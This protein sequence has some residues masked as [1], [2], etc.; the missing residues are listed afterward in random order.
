MILQRP[1]FRLYF[2]KIQHYNNFTTKFPPCTLMPIES[3]CLIGSVTWC[4]RLVYGR[5]DARTIDKAFGARTH[6]ISSLTNRFSRKRRYVRAIRCLATRD[7]RVCNRIGRFRK[8]AKHLRNNSTSSLVSFHLSWL[9]MTLYFLSIAPSA[10][11][12][13]LLKATRYLWLIVA[14]TSDDFSK[15][16]WWRRYFSDNG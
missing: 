1:N 3:V 16:N 9:F 13:R 12:W 11:V 5:L 7:M 10:V 6:A 2:G 4:L 14:F 8:V 15:T